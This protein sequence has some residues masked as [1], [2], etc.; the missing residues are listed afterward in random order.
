MDK[1]LDIIYARR[2]IRRYTQQPLSEDDL[3]SLLEAGMAAPSASNRKPWHFVVVTD[4]GT[5]QALADRH[6]YA[7]ML[8]GAGAAIAVCGDPSISSWWV[9]DCSAATENILVAA[10]ALGL[11]SVWLGCH[12][13]AE[14]EAA[15]R[16]VLGIPDTIGVLNLIS[17]GYPDEAKEARTQYDPARVH[18]ASW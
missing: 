3:T 4:A 17:V 2:S 6:P 12:P 16:E 5:L 7:K 1:R 11:G 14:R 18:V 15:V 8:P 10:A 13:V 9:Q